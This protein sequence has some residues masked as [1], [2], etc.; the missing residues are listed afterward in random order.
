MGVLRYGVGSIRPESL[1]TMTVD[2][3]P[4]WASLYI[5][6]LFV[7]EVLVPPLLLAVF[8]GICLGVMQLVS[9]VVSR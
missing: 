7:K 5:A 9:I 4:W 1:V 3:A 8:F 6:Y 2:K